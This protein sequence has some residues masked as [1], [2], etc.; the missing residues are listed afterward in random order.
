MLYLNLIRWLLP[1]FFV[2]RPPSSLEGGFKVYRY[3]NI[4]SSW[5]RVKHPRTID[6]NTVERISE[7]ILTKIY[8]S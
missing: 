4:L 1:S 7:K 8:V 2:K 6:D 3:T 5:A